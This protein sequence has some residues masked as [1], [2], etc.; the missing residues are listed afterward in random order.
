MPDANSEK[1][2]DYSSSREKHLDWIEKVIER[3]SNNSSSMKRMCLLVAGAAIGLW[4]QRRSPEVLYGA[5]GITTAFWTLDAFYLRLER[6]FRL[7]FDEVRQESASTPPDYRMKPPVLHD[8]RK[9]PFKWLLWCF[10]SG[11]SVTVFP[12]YAVLVVI[13][14]V[15]V[16]RSQVLACPTL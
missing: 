10:L 14:F 1:P 7:L 5:I 16:F 9:T 12:L 6:R 4:S 15:L 2:K 8:R 13:L 3:M 11:C